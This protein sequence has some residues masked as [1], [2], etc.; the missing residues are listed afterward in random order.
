M[1]SENGND[2]NNTNNKKDSESE[3]EQEPEKEF[4]KQF[5]IPVI[6]KPCV[7]DRSLV[8][9]VTE[10]MYEKLSSHLSIL[11]IFLNRNKEVKNGINIVI[12]C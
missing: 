4:L 12:I 3:Q 11:R 2:S 1:K 7:Y 6:I 10:S 8:E 5:N 9:E